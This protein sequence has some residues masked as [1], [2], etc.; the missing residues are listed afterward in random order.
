MIMKYSLSFFFWPYSH[1]LVDLWLLSEGLREGCS[2]SHRVQA[3]KLLVSVPHRGP[4]PPLLAQPPMMLLLGRLLCSSLQAQCSSWPLPCPGVAQLDLTCDPAR[5]KGQG[6]RTHGLGPRISG[7][8]LPATPALHAQPR[9]LCTARESTHVLQGVAFPLGILVPPSCHDCLL[10]A[11][12]DKAAAHS[13]P[14]P[15]QDAI[16]TVSCGLQELKS[17]H[18][19]FVSSSGP[20]HMQ[21]RP[22]LLWAALA[23]P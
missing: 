21:A 4:S 16:I 19:C 11:L 20:E 6:C 7:H 12:M 17:G 18:A 23:A 8:A 1:L 14:R 2:L 15:P 13:C 9:V 3:S 22:P 10:Q 5:R